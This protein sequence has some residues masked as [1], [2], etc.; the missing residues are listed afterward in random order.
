M[1]TAVPLAELVMVHGVH[2]VIEVI[3]GMQCIST[4]IIRNRMFIIIPKQIHGAAQKTVQH[5]W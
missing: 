2:M 1:H 4:R 3:I 5:L